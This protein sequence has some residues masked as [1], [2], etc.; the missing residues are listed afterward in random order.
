MSAEAY[1]SSQTEALS[2][3]GIIVYLIL[4]IALTVLILTWLQLRRFTRIW[5][6]RPISFTE[7][8]VAGFF[9][10][11]FILSIVM[12]LGG[13]VL[14]LLDFMSS[15]RIIEIREVIVSAIITGYVAFFFLRSRSV[16]GID[17]TLDYL[18]EAIQF[19]RSGQRRLDLISLMQQR[20]KRQT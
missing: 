19:R 14:T 15:H 2:F 4:P 17:D 9:A 16:V 18:K 1:R 3:R 5:I 13:I 10:W 6:D 20:Q 12:W 7:S 11:V 8:T